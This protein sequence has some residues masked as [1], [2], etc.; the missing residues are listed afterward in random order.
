MFQ[1]C[2]KEAMS[3]EC[4][5]QSS[6]W[7][8]RWLKKLVTMRGTL[9]S[10]SM[11]PGHVTPAWHQAT[12]TS[13][14]RSTLITVPGG[15]WKRGSAIQ[16]NS[17][18]DHQRAPLTNADMDKSVCWVPPHSVSAIIVDRNET[19]LVSENPPPYFCLVQCWW[20]LPHCTRAWRGMSGC[21]CL[22][23]VDHSSCVHRFCWCRRIYMV[24]LSCT[25]ILR[26]VL[27][28]S[29]V[30]GV[31]QKLSIVRVLR[32]SGPLLS[33]EIVPAVSDWE[34]PQARQIRRLNLVTITSVNIVLGAG[35]FESCFLPV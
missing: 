28:R 7:I 5:G 14:L 1:T 19:R 21:V 3:S 15:R 26:S 31:I 9:S 30:I 32:H 2:F 34:P 29:V 35:L 6:R 20:A 33:A 22:W 18:C 10:Y 17:S 24:W 23:H 8:F 4:G 12:Q 16:T 13:S 11:E 25:V 27:R